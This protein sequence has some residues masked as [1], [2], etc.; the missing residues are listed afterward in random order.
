[1]CKIYKM[2]NTIIL[3]P[4]YYECVTWSF[5]LREEPRPR[6]SEKKF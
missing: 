2:Y 6:V 3:R 4:V 1:M 5:I